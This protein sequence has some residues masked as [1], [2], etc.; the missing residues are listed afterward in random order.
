[1]LFLSLFLSLPPR[2]RWGGWPAE[3]RSG[4]GLPQQAICQ[5]NALKHPPPV[6][7]FAALTMCHPPHRSRGGR[8]KNRAFSAPLY[9]CIY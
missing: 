5:L 8:D 4:G 1:M 3:G 6:T 9:S 2:L 7:S